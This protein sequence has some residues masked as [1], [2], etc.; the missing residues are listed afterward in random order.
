MLGELEAMANGQSYQALPP[1]LSAQMIIQS[2]SGLEIRSNHCKS[3][4]TR[5]CPNICF[6]K[7]TILSI[8]PTVCKLKL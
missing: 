1:S 3:I 6:G 2:S 5:M 8:V 7:K 4:E